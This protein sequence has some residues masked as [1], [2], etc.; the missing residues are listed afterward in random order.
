[1]IAPLRRRHRRLIAVLA[2]VVPVLFVVA[3][4]G[5][6]TAPVTADLAAEIAAPPAGRVESEQGDLFDYPITTR[7]RSSES[8]WWV[9]LEPREAI[10]KPEVLVYWT[11][12]SS[13][14]RDRLPSDAFL[15]GALAGTRPR[16]F[17]VPSRALGQA[18]RLWLYSLGHQEVVDSAA[19]AAIGSLPLIEPEPAAAGEETPHEAGP[20]VTS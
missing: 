4:T 16:A 14:A 20:E 2:V 11:P 17:E 1:M 9:E 18:G 19:L 6:P 15:L 5:R 3:L 8:G 13:A 7:V 10:V 12:E